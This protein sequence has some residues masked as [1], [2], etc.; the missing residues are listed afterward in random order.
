MARTAHKSES[1]SAITVGDLNQGVICSASASR[2]RGT[3]Y[4]NSDQLLAITIPSS[5]RTIRSAS[6][7]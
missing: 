6:S 3:L 1:S 7:G 2:A 5:L 4:S